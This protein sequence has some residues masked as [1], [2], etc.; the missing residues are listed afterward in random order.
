M[1]PQI[2]NRYSYAAGN[3][4][5]YKD[6]D[7]RDLTIV[8]DFSKS[9]LSDL[10][11]GRITQNVRAAFRRAGVKNVQSLFRDGSVRPKITR[12]SDRVAHVKI[13]AVPIE[14]RGGG[15]AFGKTPLNDSR[16]TVSTAAAPKGEDA[17]VTFLSNVVAHEVGHAS[18]ALTKYSNDQFTLG[19]PI[20]PEGA[21]PGTIMEQGPTSDVLGS[22]LRAFSEEDA[23]NLQAELNEPTP[24]KR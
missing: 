6:L 7:G 8:Y 1:H 22:Q 14:A 3:P 2:W 9:G 19:T 13:I 10:E 24:E 4:L 12:A 5:K 21:Q 16:S 20:N 17:K 11:Q 18:G 23:A 15:V